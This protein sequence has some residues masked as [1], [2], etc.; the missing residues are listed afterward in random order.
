MKRR[1]ISRKKSRRTFS[2]TA[3]K[4]HKYNM[5]NPA[6]VQRGGWRM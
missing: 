1:K 6:R 2:R 4:T 3:D 5:P